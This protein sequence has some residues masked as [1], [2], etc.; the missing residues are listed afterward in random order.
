MFDVRTCVV[1]KLFI[2][3]GA[4]LVKLLTM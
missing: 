3:S 4:Q 2:I 1:V